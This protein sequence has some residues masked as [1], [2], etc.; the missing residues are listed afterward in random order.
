MV[1]DSRVNHAASSPALIEVQVYH[2]SGTQTGVFASVDGTREEE[3][4]PSG[5]SGAVVFVSCFV[6]SLSFDSRPVFWFLS[7]V[8]GMIILICGSR[9]YFLDRIKLAHS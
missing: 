8:V 7:L 5:G 2:F 6:D 9:H 4:R 1:P 3:D